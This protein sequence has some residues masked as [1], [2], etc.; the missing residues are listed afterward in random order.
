MQTLYVLVASLILAA[1]A[2]RLA[3]VCK[4]EF[5]F[6]SRRQA[7]WLF[8]LSSLALIV[9]AYFFIRE[10]WMDVAVILDEFK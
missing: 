1:L 7:R 3:F 8:L 9:V 10:K 6:F 4:E 2:H 5:L